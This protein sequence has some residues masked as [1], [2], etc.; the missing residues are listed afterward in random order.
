[1]PIKWHS[2]LIDTRRWEELNVI[3][4]T[5]DRELNKE[6]RGVE[7]PRRY[8]HTCVQYNGKIYMF[9]GRNDDDGSFK[10]R[11]Y[12]EVIQQIM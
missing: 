8:G 2:I 5:K 4:R 12:I 10:V 11:E 7:P 1:M 9:G 3:A 6:L